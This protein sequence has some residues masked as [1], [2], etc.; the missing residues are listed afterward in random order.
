[1]AT[2]PTIVIMGQSNAA[3]GG[4]NTL[5]NLQL[6][7]QGNHPDIIVWTSGLNQTLDSSNNYNQFPYQGGK[8]GCEFKLM[9]DYQAHKGSTVALLKM[10][11]GDTGLY[12]IIGERNWNI[13]SPSSLW[14]MAK[15]SFSYALYKAGLLGQ[16]LDVRAV[17]WVQG[18][19]DATNATYAAQYQTNE[20]NL[21]E[22]VRDF[23]DKPTLPWI[24]LRLSASIADPPHDESGTVN[25]AKDAIAAGDANSYAINTDSYELQADNTHYTADGYCGA[26]AGE[27]MGK[28]VFDLVKDL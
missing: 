25:A 12:N 20:T 24:S 4:N 19:K 15:A 21:R 1:M 5:D 26:T 7:L 28:D 22:A 17:V 10:A 18:E 27:S 9:T 8:F 11:K 6:G 14:N 13:S 3:G 23:F 16:T 2:I